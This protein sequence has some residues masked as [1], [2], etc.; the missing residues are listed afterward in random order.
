MIINFT[1]DNFYRFSSREAPS[2]EVRA[3][4]GGSGAR[5]PKATVSASAGVDVPPRRR[6]IGAV[7]ERL[8]AARRCVGG[9][10]RG[11]GVALSRR[12]ESAAAAFRR[13]S[14]SSTEGVRRTLLLMVQPSD[15][16]TN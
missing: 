8:S 2:T 14:T 16:V 9:G 11:A 1:L 3:G 6:C 5:R 7:D 12:T 13:S 10:T 4:E 15:E